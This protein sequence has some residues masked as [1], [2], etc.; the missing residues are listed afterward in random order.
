MGIQYG[1]YI[2]ERVIYINFYNR[3]T[4]EEYTEMNDALTEMIATST[5]DTIH[6]IQDESNVKQFPPDFSRLY[7]NSVVALGIVNGAVLTIG[8]GTSHPIMKFVSV[9]L[10]RVGKAHHERFN[11]LEEAEAHLREIDP[12]L[13]FSL[14]ERHYLEMTIMP[15]RLFL[16]ND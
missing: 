16:S 4:V 2:P 14:A 6:I 15:N 7:R 8:N 3:I 11:H 5:S 9:T 1:W 10:A 12:S 13:D